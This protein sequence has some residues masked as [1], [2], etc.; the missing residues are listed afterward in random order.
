LGLDS[1][2]DV[3]DMPHTKYQG[4]VRLRSALGSRFA[5]WQ[6]LGAL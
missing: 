4:Q 3:E 6:V 1:K 5:M 2:K